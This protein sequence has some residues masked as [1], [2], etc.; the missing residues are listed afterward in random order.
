MHKFCINYSMEQNPSW[1]ATNHSTNQKIIRILWNPEFCYRVPQEPTTGPYLT[2]VN[3]VH[4][5]PCFFNLLKPNGNYMY[6]L[7]CHSVTAFRVYGS[8]MTL[9]T[10]GDFSLDSVNQ[11]IVVK[12]NFGVLFEVWPNFLNV[13]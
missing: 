8:C 9:S 12:V 10:N 2:L 4:I 11:L 5:K 13:M 6:H 3:A 1:E 7:L